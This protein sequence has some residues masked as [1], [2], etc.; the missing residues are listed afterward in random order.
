MIGIENIPIKYYDEYK[1]ITDTLKGK[2]ITIDVLRDNEEKSIKVRLSGD[3]KFE[4]IAAIL[5]MS[6]LEKLNV[7]NSQPTLIC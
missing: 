3:G 5:S 1:P 6:E 7:Y 4:I 2:E